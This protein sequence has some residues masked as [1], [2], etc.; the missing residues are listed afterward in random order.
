MFVLGHYLFRETNNFPRARL[1]EKC[2][3]RGT[4]Y[5]QGQISEHIFKVKWRL[6]SLL[7]KI[8]I[9]LVFVANLKRALIE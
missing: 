8:I 9:W 4:Y 6:F 2:E 1:E 3:L 5:V 7:S